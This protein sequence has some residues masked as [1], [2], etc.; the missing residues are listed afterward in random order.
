MPVLI[1][2]IEGTP[3]TTYIS[4]R[5]GTSN[6]KTSGASVKEILSTLEKEGIKPIYKDDLQKQAYLH[7]ITKQKN[8]RTFGFATSTKRYSKPTSPDIKHLTS[9][10][11][12][13]KLEVT[14]LSD[15]S[16][17]ESIKKQNELIEPVHNQPEATT[18]AETDTRPVRSNLN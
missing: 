9:M 3:P 10:F 13:K 11:K 12:P 16:S 17:N 5:P 4:G 18:S 7:K 15:S 2:D 14:N 8:Q 6:V 1:T